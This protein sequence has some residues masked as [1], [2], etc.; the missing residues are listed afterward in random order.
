VE[1]LRNQQIRNLLTVT[2]LSFGVPMI[3]MGDEVRRTQRGNNNAYCQDNEL[4]WFDWSL[5]DQYPEILR[6]VRLLLK[7]RVLRDRSHEEHR[8]SLTEFL[9]QAHKEWHGVKLYQPD[10]SDN[11]HSFAFQAELRPLGL[12]FHFIL[13]GYHEPLEFELPPVE[14]DKSWR[15]WIDSALP[16]PND[17]VEWESATPVDGKTYRASA[18]SVVLLLAELAPASASQMTGVR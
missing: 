17:I 9:Y 5:A 14:T 2:V 3:S 11:S 13:N 8:V 10:W 15:R 16:S 7:R 1:Q 6:F 4:S 18:R 12:M